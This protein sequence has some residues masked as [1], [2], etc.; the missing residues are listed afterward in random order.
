MSGNGNGKPSPNGENGRDANGRFVPGWKG[1]PGNP[2]AKKVAEFRS[3]VLAVISVEDCDAVL[4]KLTKQAIAG[5]S[6]AVKE[7]LDR[8]MGKAKETVQIEG[9][10]SMLEMLRVSLESLMKRPEVA[11]ALEE[12]R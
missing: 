7:F 8:V 12:E 11:R 1:G 2:Y 10:V 4:R 3:R 5:E 6:W 9:G